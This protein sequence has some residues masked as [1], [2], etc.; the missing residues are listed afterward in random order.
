[1]TQPE[2]FAGDHT[3]TLFSAK[4]RVSSTFF[5]FPLPHSAILKMHGIGVGP[6]PTPD[7]TD[8]FEALRQLLSHLKITLPKCI[9]GS[10][11]IYSDCPR[12]SGLRI[13]SPFQP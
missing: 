12:M 1:M 8:V 3:S 11:Y 2:F 4:V 6:I 13:T 5:L 7:K 9:P 10:I